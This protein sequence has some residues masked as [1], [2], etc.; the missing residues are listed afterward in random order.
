VAGIEQAFVFSISHVLP[1]K[2]LDG[3]LQLELRFEWL[4]RRSL[5]SW[6]ARHMSALPVTYVRSKVTWK[7]NY[8]V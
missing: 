3:D 5:D 4:S 2:G 1:S 8:E 6:T 7:F